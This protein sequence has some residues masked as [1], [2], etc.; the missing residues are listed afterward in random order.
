L[1]VP[2]ERSSVWLSARRSDAWFLA[3]S[4][5]P[6]E[7]RVPPNV[8]VLLA[9][10]PCTVDGERALIRGHRLDVLVTKDSGGAM[11]RAKFTAGRDARIPVIMVDRPRP[12]DGV[13]AVAD[14]AEA[15]AWVQG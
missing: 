5:D 12:P 15:V 8:R 2:P 4:V 6:P 9:R 7:P 1:S 11:T 10:G 13:R 14:V 3:R